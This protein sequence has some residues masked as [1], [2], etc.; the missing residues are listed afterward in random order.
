MLAF[1]PKDRLT[2]EEVLEH[3]WMQGKMATQEEIS[4]EFAIRKKK[5]K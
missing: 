4:E 3:P 5:M 1:D 2:L